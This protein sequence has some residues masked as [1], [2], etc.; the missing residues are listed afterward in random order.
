LCG[1]R[2]DVG[3]DRDTRENGI[4]MPLALYA[5]TAGAFGIGVTEF[6]VM[7]L[8]LEVSADLG[9]VPLGAVAVALAALRVQR[10][11]DLV[12]VAACPEAAE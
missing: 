5:I 3:G 7:G 1:A 6:V 10:R 8:L 9:L 2:T 12:A 4:V 11:S